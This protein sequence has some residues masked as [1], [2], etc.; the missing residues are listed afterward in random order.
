MKLDSKEE[1][2][3]LEELDRAVRRLSELGADSVRTVITYADL[4]GITRA[5][6]AGSGNYF[7]QLASTGAWLKSEQDS[8]LA[9]LIGEANREEG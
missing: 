4:E 6:T 5:T 3:L 2:E 9:A 8:D 1:A 7:A